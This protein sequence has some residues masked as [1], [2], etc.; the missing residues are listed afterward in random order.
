MAGVESLHNEAQKLAKKVAERSVAARDTPPSCC[1]HSEGNPFG[2][3]ALDY[4]SIA[5]TLVLYHHQQ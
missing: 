2:K 4:K 1:Y 3:Q 5:T